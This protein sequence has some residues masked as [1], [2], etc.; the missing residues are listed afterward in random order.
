MEFT[1]AISKLE[2]LNKLQISLQDV[3]VF[4]DLFDTPPK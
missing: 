4:S 3:D 2:T 1:R